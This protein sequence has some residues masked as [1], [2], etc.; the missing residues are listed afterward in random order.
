VD[1]GRVSEAEALAKGLGRE[2]AKVLDLGRR[3]G[4]HNVEALLLVTDQRR[5]SHTVV[6]NV[7]PDGGVKLKITTEWVPEARNPLT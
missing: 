7:G 6:F 2:E 1:C 5:K 3:L 4:A